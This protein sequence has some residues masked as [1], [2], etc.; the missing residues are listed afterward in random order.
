MLKEHARLLAEANEV[1][2]KPLFAFAA[3]VPFR[4]LIALS[5][6]PDLNRMQ[7]LKRA[8]DQVDAK[9]AEMKLLRAQ[10][11][12]ADERQVALQGWVSTSPW[13]SPLPAQPATHGN[14]CSSRQPLLP[15]GLARRE[16]KRLRSKRDAG[17]AP[18]APA[19][20]LPSPAS[21]PYASHHL[22]RIVCSRRSLAA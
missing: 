15:L 10:L 20:K 11:A 16:V 1:G 4:S 9:Q 21:P 17:E 2:T 14:R 22:N 5:N 8:L 13:A 19:G 12:Q 7:A 3:P 6:G 18:P